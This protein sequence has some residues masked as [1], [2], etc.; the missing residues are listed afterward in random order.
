MKKVALFLA[1]VLCLSFLVGCFDIRNLVKRKYK[2][3]V[4]DNYDLHVGTLD[5]Y[6]ESGTEI[7]VYVK[8]L[9]GPLAGINVNGV[10]SVHEDMKFDMEKACQYYTFIMPSQ[11]SVLYLTLNERTGYGPIDCPKGYH[12]WDDGTF[13][14]DG[15][16]KIFYCTGC[17]KTKTVSS[18]S[19]VLD[20]YWL[21]YESE[22]DPYMIVLYQG[23]ACEIKFMDSK[24]SDYYQHYYIKNQKL[25]I[26]INTASKYH[27]FYMTKNAL[28][29]D[30]EE[31]TANLWDTMARSGPVVYFKSGVSQSEKLSIITMVGRNLEG[32]PTIEKIYGPYKIGNRYNDNTDDMYAFIA[33]GVNG[34]ESWSDKILG[35]DY[36]FTYTEGREILV[37][38]RGMLL[39]LD[40]AFDRELITLDIL[41]ELYENNHDC[42][43]E[44]A[45]DDGVLTKNEDGDDIILYTC[46][47]CGVTKNIA[48]PD[49]FSF[50]LTWGFDG[51][52]DSESGQLVNGYNYELNSKCE[53]TLV[54]EHEELMNIYRVFY[55]GGL[56]D[57]KESF[58]ASE[59]LYSPSYTIE[60]SYTVNGEKI[61]FSILGASY[62]SYSEW[63]IHSALGF[64]YDKVICE[65]ITSSE[66]YKALP[67]NTNMYE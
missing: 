65:F 28:I 41:A 5:E 62:L 52:Y 38:I 14:D 47:S 9:S 32:T 12:S 33:K 21:P 53:G 64:A 18:N 35:T 4:V 58:K 2:L 50:S 30:P 51:K 6:Y 42:A 59:M 56:F 61:T 45:Y 16:N 55:N 7:R 31:S 44:H 46:L 22:T 19:L 24:K 15:K 40:E 54:L 27:V 11:D 43:I 1:L 26:D 25:Y 49:D 60:M 63:E 13:I 48:L 20:Y 8:F 66:E 10:G 29:F 34:R 36:T 37:Y 57:I 67:P 17:D 23:D 39:S 3:T